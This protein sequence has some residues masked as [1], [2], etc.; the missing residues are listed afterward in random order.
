VVK[1]VLKGQYSAGAVR[2][3]VARKYWKLGIETIGES[4][5]IPTGP[6]VVGPGT[7]FLIVES[8]KR[9][10]LELNPSDESGKTILNHLDEDFRNG[11]TEASDRDYAGIRSKFNA[12]P[13]TCG[14]G[15]HPKIKW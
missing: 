5:T 10:L 2:D 3:S 11:F 13:Q 7:P 4:E 8:I 1:A 15:C 9:A 14:K 12:I 6:L